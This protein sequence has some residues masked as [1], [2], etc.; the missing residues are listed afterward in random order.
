[1]TFKLEPGRTIILDAPAATQRYAFVTFPSSP[2]FSLIV[3][4]TFLV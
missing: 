3:R 2:T 1:M 4:Q